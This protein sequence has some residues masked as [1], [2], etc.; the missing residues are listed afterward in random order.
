MSLTWTS[1]SEIDTRLDQLAIDIPN[2]PWLRQDIQ[3]DSATLYANYVEILKKAHSHGS[4]VLTL[5]GPTAGDVG[6][7]NFPYKLSAVNQTTFATRL[8]N[9]HR[10]RSKAAGEAPDAWEIGNELDQS[11]FNADDTTDE[12]LWDQGVRR[13]PLD[14]DHDDPR[15]V[16]DR[17]DRHVRNGE[18]ARPSTSASTSP[19]PPRR[20]RSSTTTT[21]R[22]SSPRW[23]AT[24]RT[25]TPAP[26]RSRRR[27][28]PIFQQYVAAGLTD[29]P[30]YV[31]E[32]GFHRAEATLTT[33]RLARRRTR[34]GSST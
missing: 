32:W 28:T 20:S 13:V 19:I 18:R 9:L 2:V 11:G 14:G 7:G 22:I 27:R 30:I 16:P 5:L 26:T 8:N 31:T 21:A 17:E 1:I 15:R 6:G 34:R 33:G 12:T 3:D 29:K 23:T 25:S 4:K 24:A 10:L